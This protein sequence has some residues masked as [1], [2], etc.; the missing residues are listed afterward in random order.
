[1]TQ[2]SSDEVTY[3]VERSNLRVILRLRGILSDFHWIHPV[4]VF[5]LIEW[6]S[7]LKSEMQIMSHRQLE[8]RIWQS[9]IHLDKHMIHQQTEK[10]AVINRQAKWDHVK[11]KKIKM[12]SNINKHA[13]FMT[14]S[15]GYFAI[16]FKCYVLF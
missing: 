3:W 13:R 15:L 12:N 16:T 9:V 14:Y 1:M 8:Q 6:S 10:L 11:L 4:R 5:E 7:R 2:S